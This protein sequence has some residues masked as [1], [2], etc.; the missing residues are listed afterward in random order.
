MI[1]DRA[2]RGTRHR[3]LLAPMGKVPYLEAEAAG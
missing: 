3:P 2:L 1:S